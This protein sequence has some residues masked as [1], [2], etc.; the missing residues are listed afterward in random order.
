MKLSLRTWKGEFCSNLH[1]IYF[2]KRPK[3]DLDIFKLRKKGRVMA[4]ICLSAIYVNYFSLRS[5]CSNTSKALEEVTQE[6]DSYRR[7]VESFE[8]KNP[9]DAHM[10]K[11]KEV[12][13]S[14]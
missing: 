10:V 8:K 12:R 1:L 3:N 6:R 11:V 14:N 5:Q 2:G 7:Q 9:D 4:S 13:K